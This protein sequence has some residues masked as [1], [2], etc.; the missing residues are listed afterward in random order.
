MS[1]PPQTS[2]PPRR[3]RTHRRIGWCIALVA[4]T[5][6]MSH[7]CV[8][9]RLILFPSRDPLPAAGTTSQQVAYRGTETVQVVVARTPEC[10]GREPDAFMLVFNGNA[11][12]A[13]RAVYYG[14]EMA[15]GRAVE[16]WSMNYPGYGQSQSIATL[17]DIAPA[18]LAT[19]DALRQHAGGRPILVHGNSIGT[20]AALAVAA[21]RPAAGLVLN[22]PAPLKQLILRRHGWW[23]LWLIAGPVAWSVPA[24]LDAVAN[25]RRCSIPAVF[26]LAGADTII[27]PKYQK[28]VVDAYAGEKKAVPIPDAD[29]NDAAIGDAAIEAEAAVDALWERIGVRNV[30]RPTTTQPE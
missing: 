6:V 25:A 23:N 12:R 15:E 9:D 27:P 16:V 2:A 30:T 5:L 18:A 7:G 1:A 8:A 10:R 11:D 26:V 21:S 13:E 29:H 28:L 19:Y 14:L 22:N 3:R 24:D 17:T 4:Y 20:T